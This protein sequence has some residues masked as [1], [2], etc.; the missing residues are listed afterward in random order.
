MILHICKNHIAENVF[1]GG[2]EIFLAKSYL[3]SVNQNYTTKMIQLVWNPR[4]AL[5]LTDNQNCQKTVGELSET[6][7]ELAGGDCRRNGG[8]W[9]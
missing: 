2:Y 5:F 8:S 4:G 3:Q 7:R 6:V 1:S 9:R